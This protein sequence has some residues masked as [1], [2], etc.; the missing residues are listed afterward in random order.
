MNNYISTTEDLNNLVKFLSK[1]KFLSLDTEFI[2]E[3]YY[4]PK[5][6]LLQISSL[7]DSFIIDPL[8]EKIDLSSFWKIIYNDKI[9]IVMHSCRQDLEIFH[10]IN[11]ELPKNIFDTQIAA[12]VC[13]YG[14][15]VGYDKL[16]KSLFNLNIDK[17]SRTSDWSI[18]P[19]NNKQRLYAIDDVK[20]LAKIYPILKN[21][22]FKNKRSKWIEDEFSK[23]FV[24]ENYIL[25]PDL[26]WQRINIKTSNREVINRIKFL[27]GWREDYAQKNNLPRNYILKDDL[28]IEIAYQCPSSSQDFLKIR[29]FHK[30]KVKFISDILLFLSKANSE[31]KEN[32]PSNPNKKKSKSYP[33]II[34]LLKIL[35]KYKSE[36]FGVAQKL[37]ASTNDLENLSIGKN[38]NLNCLKGWRFEIFGKDALEVCS[39]KKAIKIE[40]NKLIIF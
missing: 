21:E 1:E 13:G 17:S 25:K 19:L 12:M 2:R 6:C 33:I 9:T 5:L 27:A 28:I 36:T 24:K 15:Q 3:G 37:I 7:K 34:E 14:D 30:N 35:L 8:S 39:G 23:L 40:N 38:N 29:G 22:L 31:P 4:Y 32:W 11:G 20:F 18:R 26:A 16:V 10:N